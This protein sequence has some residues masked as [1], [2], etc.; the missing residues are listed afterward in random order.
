MGVVYV[1]LKIRN[2]LKAKQPI[3]MEA[4]VDSGATLLV[5]PGAVA[6]EL[7][8]P[9]IRTQIVKYANEQ[10][11]ERD[12]VWGVEVELCGRK[13]IFEAVVEPEKNYPLVGAVVMES[14]DLIVEPRSLGV[15]PN[16]RSKLPMAE[17]E[18]MS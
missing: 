4:K 10:T 12:V 6:K 9:V 14:L 13:G 8:F 7:E 11:A 15:Y 17:I 5:I 16:P 1:T 18:G 2:P 3:E